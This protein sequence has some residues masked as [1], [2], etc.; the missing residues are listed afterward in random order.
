MLFVSGGAAL[1]FQVAWMRELRLV[2]GATTA[3]VAAVLA[4]FM[5]GLGLGSAVLGPRADRS[6]NPL[7]LY[8][9]L[10]TIVALSVAVS[11]FLV[12]L[13]SQLYFGLG[14]QVALGVGG[15]TVVRLLLA[16]L[17][18]GVPTFV[19]G[20]TLPAAVRSV[21]AV[22][23]ERRRALAVLYGVNTL[24]AV[25]GTYF[26][27]FFSLETLG[28]RATLWLGC[29]MNLLIGLAAI[30]RSQSLAPID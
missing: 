20:G 24:G 10:E 9:K 16:A 29:A 25:C 12:G 8:G 1:V 13:A 4:I 23:D 15:A 18:L 27:T 22:G 21:T 11:P 2:F 14:G 3:A 26:A 30:K 6:P 5:A 19:M 7:R 17:V 28:T